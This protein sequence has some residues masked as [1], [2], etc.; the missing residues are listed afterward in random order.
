MA[1]VTNWNPFGVAFDITA[2]A[3]TVTRTSATRYT[4]KL[5]LFVT[6]FYKI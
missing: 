6:Q 4:V 5:T 3:G 2:T 1:T